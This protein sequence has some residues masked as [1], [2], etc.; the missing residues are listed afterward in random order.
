MNRLIEFNSAMEKSKAKEIN[1]KEVFAVIKKRYLVVLA[2]VVIFGLLGFVYGQ[3]STNPLYQTSSRII[4]KAGAEDRATLQ[5][6][7][8]DSTIME[9]VVERLKIDRSPEAVAGQITVQ[10]I[11]GSQ[12]VSISVIDTDPIMAASIADTTATVFKEE[13]PKIVGFNDVQLLS[14]A[15]VN[16]YPI[17]DTGNRTFIISIILGLVLG[18]GLVFFLDSLDDTVQ[19]VQDV[20]DYLGTPVLGNV[21]KMKKHNFKKRNKTEK[22]LENGGE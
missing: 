3:L 7:M 13:I 21:S 20:E 5:V 9:K 18:I 2:I 22:Q 12:V 14:E 16:P 17:N 1:L 10:S 8:K 15:N 6:I 4:I 19:S 11:D